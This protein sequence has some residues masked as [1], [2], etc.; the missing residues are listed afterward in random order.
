[1]S[2]KNIYKKTHDFFE[3]H[4]DKKAVDIRAEKAEYH[5]RQD[6]HNDQKHNGANGIRFEY[7]KKS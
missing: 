7:R 3:K 2:T 4:I 1:M 6:Y 5:A